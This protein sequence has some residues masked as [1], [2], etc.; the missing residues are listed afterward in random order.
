MLLKFLTYNIHYGIGRDRRYDLNRTIE[1]IIQPDGSLKIDAVGF[2]GADCE[3]ATAF[4]EEAL[5]E[6][7][8]RQKKPEYYRQA[9]RE[10]RV[11]R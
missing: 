10:Q 9:R 1:V 6:T 5:G 8:G 2:Q 3:K 4:L 11:G 7:T